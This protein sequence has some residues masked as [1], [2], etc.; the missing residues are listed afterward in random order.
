MW[1][2][3][4][5]LYEM[6]T[7]QR[8]FDA[9]DISDTVAAVLRDE[10][11]WNAFP[12]DVPPQIRRVVKRC[13]DKDRNTRIPDLS[14][15]RFLMNEPADAGTGASGVVPRRARWRR[16]LPWSL[17][18]AALAVA[19]AVVALRPAPQ[20]RMT[21]RLSAEI[22]VDA[23]LVTDSGPAAAVS[24][25]GSMIA[26]VAQEKDGNPQLY[27]RRLEQLQATRLPGTDGARS[28]FFSPD[29]QWVAFFAAGKLKKISVAGSAP[30]MLSD[31]GTARGGDWA[32]DDTIVFQPS[33]IANGL[34]RVSANGGKPESITTLGEG[35]TRQRWPQVLP[36]ARVVLYTTTS[37][38]GTYDTAGSVVVQALPNGA[39]KVL[40]RG[41]GA[42]NLYWQRADG[43]GDAQRLTQ[44]AHAQNPGSWHSTGRFFAFMESNPRTSNDIMI[45]PMEGDDRS[46]WKPGT[47]TV[48]LNSQSNEAQPTFSPD[49]RWM[50]Y[51][52]TES[53]HEEVYVRPFPGPG[54][55]WQVSSDASTY[56]TP[57]WSRAR[58]ELFY[59]STNGRL[60]VVAYTVEGDS[61]K[62]DKPRLWS[63][64]R[65]MARPR[66]ALG[67]SFDLH[68]DGERFALATVPQVEAEGQANTV[69]FIFNF[70]DE[71]KRLPPLRP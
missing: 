66:S 56:P 1:A 69:I 7:G 24:P 65:V 34:Q 22:G 13:L 47:P 53:G 62:V 70:F 60:M 27:I 54:G 11:D 48:F 64:R 19:V 52:S 25:D 21:P 12:R 6:L 17:A 42:F 71:L 30:I 3:G 16:A 58:N 14:V 8:A 31:V 61:F 29:G 41:S 50:A 44:S 37:T 57:T 63:D 51:V 49:G 35:E 20:A 68:P 26:F 15:A 9:E 2:F 55:K 5:V 10:P 32:E 46:A 59:T 33:N 38:P 43:T 39:R 45:L 28:P 23:S 36:G 18:G 4:C 67:R 40:V